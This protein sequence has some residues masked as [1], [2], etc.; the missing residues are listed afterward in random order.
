[1]AGAFMIAVGRLAKKAHKA[2]K[3]QSITPNLHWMAERLWCS[4]WLLLKRIHLGLYRFFDTAED[5]Y[6]VEALNLGGLEHPH[7]HVPGSPSDWLQDGVLDKW[8]GPIGVFDLPLDFWAEGVPRSTQGACR[9][10]TSRRVGSMANSL[11]RWRPLG[12][13]HRWNTLCGF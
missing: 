13:P 12:Y 2:G 1:M 10:S 4:M 7:F 11:A 8:L 6:M 9:A 5:F 3:I